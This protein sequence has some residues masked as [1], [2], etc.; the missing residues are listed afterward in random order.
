MWKVAEKCPWICDP[1][2]LPWSTSRVWS[3]SDLLQHFYNYTII[4][5][6][7]LRKHSSDISGDTKCFSFQNIHTA[8]NITRIPLICATKGV[9]KENHTTSFILNIPEINNFV[10]LRCFVIWRTAL[11]CCSVW[12]YSCYLVLTL[13][14]CNC[15]TAA[16]LSAIA[17]SSE[18]FVSNF[19]LTALFMLWVLVFR[20]WAV[21]PSLLQGLLMALKPALCSYHINRRAL[22]SSR[23]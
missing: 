10:H 6:S 9:R 16:Q 19:L 2:W 20:S 4:N 7:V 12:M 8:K 13:C 15:T 3:N 21:L 11:L 22:Q 23:L 14:K 17:L 18:H 5:Y 1:A